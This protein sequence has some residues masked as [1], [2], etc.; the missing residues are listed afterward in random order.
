MPFDVA[1]F[2]WRGDPL[3]SRPRHWLRSVL[4]SL[5]EMALTLVALLLAFSVAFAASAAI[6]GL[7][8]FPPTGADTPKLPPI[9]VGSQI[10]SSASFFLVLAGFFRWRWRQLMAKL[11]GPLA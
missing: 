1:G 7:P 9:P 4:D 6:Y 3:P 10:V 2:G 11:R 5:M 8:D